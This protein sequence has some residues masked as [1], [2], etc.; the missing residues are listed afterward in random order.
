MVLGYSAGQAP[1]ALTGDLGALPD[2]FAHRLVVAPPIDAVALVAHRVALVLTAWLTAVT[3]AHLLSALAGRPRA[4]RVSARF[5]P[6][7]VRRLVAAAVVTAGTV[8]ATGPW[9]PAGAEPRSGAVPGVGGG[10]PPVVTV[11]DGRA[12]PD[13]TTAFGTPAPP[14]T[15]AVAPAAPAGPVG[16]SPVTP[17]TVVAGIAGAGDTGGNVTHVTVAPGDSLWTLTRDAIARETG[18]DPHTIG[19]DE[20]ASRWVRV[21][22]VNRDRLRSGDVNVLAPGEDVVIPPG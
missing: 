3:V 18:R 6:H 8:T 13:A 9:A 4:R 19:G 14:T 20:L 17:T 2:R 1:F 11:R 15:V 12:P 22:E 7:A 21:C 16:R 10:D 5:T